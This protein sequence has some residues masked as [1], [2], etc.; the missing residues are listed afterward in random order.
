MTG[1]YNVTDNLTVR[2]GVVFRNQYKSLPRE[3]NVSVEFKW[4]FQI[5]RI[6]FLVF[7]VK[8]YT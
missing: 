1:E 8:P 3:D 5:N 4:K 2:E 7:R 6:N